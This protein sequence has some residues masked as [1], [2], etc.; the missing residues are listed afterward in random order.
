MKPFCYHSF[1]LRQL[2]SFAEIARTGSFRQAAKTLHIAQP[3]LSRQIKQLEAALGI[4]LFDRTPRHL[5]LTIEGRELAGRLPDLFSQIDHLT[6]TVKGASTGGTGQ[7]RIGDAGVLTTEVIAPA[8]RRLRKRWPNLRLSA[9][10]NTSEGFFY[11]LLEDRIDCAF[12]ALE[13]K[14]IEL[15]SHKLSKLEIGLVLPPGHRL[16][17]HSEI[18]LERLRNERW[19]FPP[20]EANPVLYDELISCCHKTGFTPDVIAEMTQRPR[21]ISQVACGIGIATL[22]QTMMHLCIGGTTFHRL[23]RPTPMIDCYLVYR[24]NPSSL[25]L[26]SFISICLELGRDFRS[27]NENVGNLRTRLRTDPLYQHLR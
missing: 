17:N 20:R 13:P 7:L 14:S 6:E 3:A 21:V 16:A 5:H 19:I 27:G 26:K 9:V 24:K 11:D 23:I 25:L 8:L 2:V 12:P 15:T 22:V 4:Y 1:D 10:Q 18:R